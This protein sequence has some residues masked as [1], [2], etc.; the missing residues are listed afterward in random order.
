[1]NF[2]EKTFLDV[3]GVSVDK[4]APSLEIIQGDNLPILQSFSSEQFSLIYIDPPFNTGHTQKRLQTQTKRDEGGNRIGYKGKVYTSKLIG[5]K[6]FDDKFDDYLGFLEPRLHEAYRLLKNDGSLFLHID[7]REVHYA[8]I[9]LDEIF[10]RENFINEI[11]WSYDYGARSTTKWSAKHDNILWYAKDA[12]NYCFNYGEIDRIPY[13]APK[14]VG[15]EKAALGK[16]PTSVWWATIVSPTGKEKTGYPTQK[17][18][19]ILE[20]IVKVHSRVGDSVLDF[21]AGSGSFGEAAV[22]NNRNVILIDSS[23]EAIDV[24]KNRFAG[25]YSFSFLDKSNVS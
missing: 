4:L 23:Q 1:M 24:M 19:T 14:L 20:R 22:K 3:L 17:P 8:K 5:V 21:F 12:N 10:G 9:L 16:C 2:H 15:E 11:I 18:L 7:Y 6:S 25:K 13:M